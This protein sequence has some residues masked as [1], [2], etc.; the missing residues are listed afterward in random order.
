M[1]YYF[2]TWFTP[3]PVSLW[4]GY[5]HASSPTNQCFQLSKDLQL[6]WITGH[7]GIPCNSALPCAAVTSIVLKCVI[8]VVS[9]PL[10]IY[11]SLMVLS[12]V[13]TLATGVFCRPLCSQN[14]G[15]QH[16][17]EE[18]DKERES[19]LKKFTA[20]VCVRACVRACVFV[21]CVC[22]CGVCVCVRVCCVSVCVWR[23]CVCVFVCVCVCVCACVCVCVS[24]CV[25]VRVR[26]CVR[27][28]MRVCVACVCLCLCVCMHVRLCM[29]TYTL[30]N[31]KRLIWFFSV[32]L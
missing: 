14:A 29:C 30:F 10:S 23:V 6:W 4:T 2:N 18:R 27:A 11:W 17:K 15:E 32:H 1:V 22:V 28:C 25:C 8:C 12:F 16:L 7:N 24:V 5:L 13:N 19:G 21:W 26:A 3:S 20:C 31:L 9:N